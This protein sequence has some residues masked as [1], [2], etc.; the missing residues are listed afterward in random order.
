M[1]RPVGSKSQ[2][3]VIRDQIAMVKGITPL[4]AMLDIMERAIKAG[5]D[6]TALTAAAD[7]APYVHSKMPI[8][9]EVQGTINLTFGDGRDA[10]I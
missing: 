4:Q 9:A 6:K 2:K 1:A 10:K 8:R 3:K 5:D 7:A